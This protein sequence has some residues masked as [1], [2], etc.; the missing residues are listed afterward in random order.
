[1]K[2]ECVNCGLIDETDVCEERVV[3]LEPMGDHKVERVSYYTKC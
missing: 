1:M 2:Y 3:D